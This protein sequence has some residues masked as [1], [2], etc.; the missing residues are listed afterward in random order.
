MHWHRGEL[1]FNWECSVRELRVHDRQARSSMV[2]KTKAHHQ[3]MAMKSRGRSGLT[4]CASWS[5]TR[6]ASKPNANA[7]TSWSAINTG[8]INKTI[9][10]LAIDPAAPSTLYAGTGGGLFK[11]TDGANGL[12]NSFKPAK[13]LMPN[14]IFLNVSLRT[15]DP[16]NEKLRGLKTAVLRVQLWRRFV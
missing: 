12:R 2:S 13:C 9:Y 6:S 15:T 7:G 11:S 4:A 1:I 14:E 16:E 10:S 3:R 8:L 5:T